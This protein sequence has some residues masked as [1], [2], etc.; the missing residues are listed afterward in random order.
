MDEFIVMPNHIHGILIITDLDVGA[1]HSF[2]IKMAVIN[3]STQNAS[4]LQSLTKLE[5]HRDQNYGSE[6]ILIELSETIRN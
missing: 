5:K 4:P 6:I 3:Q 1:K 2:N